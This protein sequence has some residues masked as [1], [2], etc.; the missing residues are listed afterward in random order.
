MI[1]RRLSARL[2]IWPLK[3]PFHISRGVRTET[4][5]VRAELNHCGV[6][7]YGE[8]VPY[9]RYG[10]TT[11]SVITRI[12]DVAAA[13]EEGIS[14]EE[15]QAILPPGAARNAVDCALW[16]M[17]SRWKEIPVWQLLH[18]PGPASVTTAV[19]ISIG[20][21]ED[22]AEKALH[23]KDFPLLKVKLDAENI[24]ERITAIR[25]AAPNPRIILDPNESWSMEH[26]TDLNNFLEE[27]N[28]SLLEQPLAAG[29]DDDLRYFSGS[30]PICADESCH[31]RQDLEGLTG[32]YQVINIKLD[33]TGGLTE[34][35]KLKQQAEAMGFG[36]MIGCMVATSLAMA[37]AML[38]APGADFVDLDGPLLI[39]EDR[40]NGLDI[41]QGHIAVPS[42][43][44]WGG[45]VKR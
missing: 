8:A 35:V 2:E 7:G 40:R 1:S 10:E 5:V 24:R 38:L 23:Y 36:I 13:V 43:E 42:P 3:E 19:T 41:T 34:A 28:I 44:L 22:M 37:P 12:E 29:H 31:T 30:I 14:P 6:S 39:K 16:D 15:L 32:K 20:K 26:L 9:A 21:A 18:L 4:R 45:G 25:S 27:M 11:D 33:K 17:M